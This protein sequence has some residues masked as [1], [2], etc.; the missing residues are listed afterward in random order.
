MDRWGWR[1]QAIDTGWRCDFPAA[2]VGGKV[3]KIPEVD[4]GRAVTG[5]ND[6]TAFPWHMQLGDHRVTSRAQFDALAAEGGNFTG[7]P[8]FPAA[9]GVVVFT[10]PDPQRATLALV[11]GSVGI[12]TVAEADDLYLAPAEQNLF[13]RVNNADDATRDWHA[14]AMVSFPRCVFSTAWL[15]DRYHKEFKARFRNERRAGHVLPELF[16]CRNSIARDMW[17]TPIE[18]DG[19]LRVG[20]MGSPSHVWDIDLAHAAFE[21]AK[22]HGCETW[23]MGY[24]PGHLDKNPNEPETIT[25]E[26]GTV[27]DARSPASRAAEADWR[28][29]IDRHQKWITPDDYHRVAIPFDIG[30]APLQYNQFTSGKSDVKAIEYSISG[31]ACVLANTPAYNMAGWKHRENCMLANHPTEYAS[32]VQELIVDRG[33]R[34]SLVEAARDMVWNERNED[35]LRQE[36]SDALAL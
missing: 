29:V 23:M 30:I 13:T 16:V 3:V 25:L 4:L 15:R 19:P 14:R 35:V 28:R 8:V 36:W 9:E 32:A 21:T 11:M 1:E 2:A 34:E 18:R 27:H 24:S 12:L 33:L 22:A 5:P 26:D 20:F 17:P 31:A 7:G 10:R 6:D